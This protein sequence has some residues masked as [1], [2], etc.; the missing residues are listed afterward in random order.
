MVSPDA[1]GEPEMQIRI[2]HWSVFA[3]KHGGDVFRIDGW[4][5]NEFDEPQAGYT[6]VDPHNDNAVH[7]AEVIRTCLEHRGSII[8]VEGVRMKSRDRG[9][10]NA[11]SRPYVIDIINK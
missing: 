1:E 8:C 10:W 11:D 6:F 3:S 9:L 4:F 2:D 7:W 5:Q